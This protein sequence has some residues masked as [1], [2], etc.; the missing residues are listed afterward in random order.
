M[1]KL[2]S[3]ILVVSIIAGVGIFNTEAI[4][5]SSSSST[6]FK[7]GKIVSCG[8]YLFSLVSKKGVYKDYLYRT[9]KSG[10]NA[11]LISKKVSS[12]S[13]LYTYNKKL[14]YLEDNKIMCYNTKTLKKST[15]KKTKNYV[16]GICSKGIIVEDYN[17]G[18]YLY[19]FK[20]KSI[21]IVGTGYSVAGANKKY[22][23]YTKPIGYN[24]DTHKVKVK[25]YRYTIKNGK[26]KGLSSVMAS[27]NS[28]S[29][30]YS[31]AGVATFHVFSK[32][33]IFI[34]GSFGGSAGIFVG[35]VFKMNSDGTGIKKLKSSVQNSIM[36]GKKCVYVKTEKQVYKISSKGKLTKK[37]KI[38]YKKNILTTTTSNYSVVSKN[39]SGSNYD[40]YV[41][42]S[43]STSLKKRVINAKSLI[44]SSDPSDAYASSTLIGIVGNMALVSVR[45][46]S[47]E[48]GNGS[49]GWRPGTVRLINYLVNVKTGKKV[50]I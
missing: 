44:K 11:K 10:K 48:D 13:S 27:N 1:K 16:Q 37:A 33:N 25:L 22:I 19:T 8:K 5:A 2:L 45:V 35:D 3:I 50:K 38:S 43:V 34:C 17:K 15:F 47:Y 12:P 9:N 30:D 42:R 46:Y 32:V 18:L 40:L 23:F 7:E 29:Y 41:N 28:S 21:K 20:G 6:P 26:R 39:T 24:N 4:T 49:V 31:N 14:Y 36:P